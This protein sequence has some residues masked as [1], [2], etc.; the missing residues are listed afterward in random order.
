MSLKTSLL[1]GLFGLVGLM[2]VSSAFAEDYKINL[3][4]PNKVG[5]EYANSVTAK[6]SRTSTAVLNGQEQEESKDFKSFTAACKGTVKILMIDD[7]AKYPTRIRYEVESLTKDGVSLYPQGTVIIARLSGNEVTF[8]IDGTQPDVEHTA[9]IAVLLDL[10]RPNGVTNEDATNEPYKP[11]K[12]GDTW[13]IN[14]SKSTK[15]FRSEESLQVTPDQLKGQS[16]LVDVKDLNGQKALVIRSSITADGLKKDL[17]DGS[18]ISDGKIT[19][20]I[21]EVLPVDPTQPV[22]SLDTKLNMTITMN[23]HF[24]STKTILHVKSDR[25]E[26]RAAITAD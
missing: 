18:S 21:N 12:V 8:D 6:V 22:I 25:K 20:E 1:R 10:S 2:L 5:N 26:R 24:G 4:R 15:E 19:C 16:K 7:K 23:P 9:V 3:V 13:P 17:P 14:A 11:Q